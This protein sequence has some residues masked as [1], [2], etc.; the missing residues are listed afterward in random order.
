[1][2]D[3]SVPSSRYES[4]E[5]TN[6]SLT[7]LPNPE[8]ISQA[9]FIMPLKCHFGCD[10]KVTTPAIVQGAMHTYWHTQG[11]GRMFLEPST[12]RTI[13]PQNL[14]TLVIPDESISRIAKQ[15]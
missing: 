9:L 5:S 1:M 15:R 3:I 13:F 4:A 2:V 10:T 8:T 14:H 6:R 7:P 12:E 11:L